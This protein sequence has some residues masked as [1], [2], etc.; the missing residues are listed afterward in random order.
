MSKLSSLTALLIAALVVA[1]P[2]QDAQKY[3]FAVAKPTKDTKFVNAS[4]TSMSLEMDVAMN[5][6]SMMQ[7]NMQSKEKKLVE[8]TVLAVND[9]GISKMRFAL[10]Q[11]E[12]S[13]KMQMMGQDQDE[14]ESDARLGGTFTVEM[15]DGA[16]V[17]TDAEGAEASSDIVEAF[18]AELEDSV[19][20]G[21]LHDPTARLGKI[22]GGKE[23]AIN[24]KV[25][26]SEE[27]I[28]DFLKGA[29]DQLDGADVNI[30]K[31]TLTL[32]RT[33]T[34]LGTECGVF[35]AELKFGGKGDEGGMAMSMSIQVDGEFFVGLADCWVYKMQMKGPLEMK[36]GQSSP[37][38]EVAMNGKGELKHVEDVAISKGK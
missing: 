11:F 25:D 2:A 28:K 19:A 38:G 14:S 20:E 3:K 26:M 21:H 35:K 23:L 5:G 29:N 18:Q 13:Q 37:E 32:V 31:A 12:N 6:Q 4:D 22:L 7:M 16:L 30:E 24:E 17:V 9:K 10:K 36:G 8:R 15:K 27:M 1:A 33:V 34:Y